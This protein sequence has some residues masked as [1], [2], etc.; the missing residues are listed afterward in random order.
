FESSPLIAGWCEPDDPTAFSSCLQE[1][2]ARYPQWQ[3][4]SLHPADLVGEFSWE[5]RIAKIL[6]RV[7]AS[8][9]P[10]VG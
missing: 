7:D 9:R 10:V 8:V 5:R 3:E 4:E 6:D 1:V 2:L